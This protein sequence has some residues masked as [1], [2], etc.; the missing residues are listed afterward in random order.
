MSTPYGQGGDS[1][2]PQWSGYTGDQG[3]YGQQGGDQY[4]QPQQPQYGQPQQQPQ[5]GQPQQ[6]P[7]YG[8]PQYGQP[9]QQPQYGQPQYGQPQQPQYGQQGGYGQAGYGQQPYNQYGSQ[10]P[11]KK[12][13]KPLIF[14]GVGLVVVLAIVAVLLFLWP[15]FSLTKVTADSIQKQLAIKS[16]VPASDIKCPDGEKAFSKHTFTCTLADG[17]KIDVTMT[18]E[19][20]ASGNALFENTDPK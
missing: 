11:A 20:D 13:N 14:G 8:Q 5:Y 3:Q 1:G 16:G 15:G 19:K 4:G 10:T 17:R 2:S 18:G 9:P 12:S 7:Q 6:Q